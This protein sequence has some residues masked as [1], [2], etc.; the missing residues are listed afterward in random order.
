L[1]PGASS[2]ILA[3]Y[4]AFKEGAKTAMS[5]GYEMIGTVKAVMEPIT[6][7]SGFF[8][9]EFVITTEDERFPQPIKFVTVKERCALVDGL[10]PNDRVRV[11]F[12]IRGTLSTKNGE[13]YFVDLQAFQV[14]KLDGGGTSVSRD[15]AE[16]P[17]VE[18][19][20]MPF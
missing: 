18:D 14:E 5:T 19:E 13:R 17:P 9:R 2:G 1:S 6:F 12:D 20:P 7:P 16:P 8:K 4:C 15:A 10:A 3:F 11:R